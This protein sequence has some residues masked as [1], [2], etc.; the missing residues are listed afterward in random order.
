MTSFNAYDI[1]ACLF[2]AYR[3][4][5]FIYKTRPSVSRI[6]PRVKHGVSCGVEGSEISKYCYFVII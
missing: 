6:K 5:L 1:F 2:N 3:A 4:V